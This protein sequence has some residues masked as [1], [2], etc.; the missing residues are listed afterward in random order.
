MKTTIEIPD[1]ILRRARSAA[2]ERGISFREFVME[3]LKAKLTT[4]SRSRQRPW[5]AGFGKL[6]HL[7]K[8]TARIMRIIEAEKRL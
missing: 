1:R 3:A 7:R 8:E 6:R 5:M 2:G 4:K